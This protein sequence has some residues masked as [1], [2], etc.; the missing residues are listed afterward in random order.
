MVS[1][2]SDDLPDP[3][4]P[5]ITT[6]RFRG[7]AQLTFFKLCWAAPRT[8]RKSIATSR[9]NTDARARPLAPGRPAEGE[10]GLENRPHRRRPPEL[11]RAPAAGV[12]TPRNQKVFGSAAGFARVRRFG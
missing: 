9:P 3:L 4:G 11:F 10:R 8:T 2:A 5:V 12:R 6:R 1:K 7:S